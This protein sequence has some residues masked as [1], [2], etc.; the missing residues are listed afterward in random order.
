M[1]EEGWRR[2][3]EEQMKGVEEEGGTEERMEAEVDKR[4]AGRIL[5]Q[6]V[7]VWVEMAG[8]EGKRRA[9]KVERGQKMEGWRQERGWME[10]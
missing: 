8:P 9:G 10:C 4:G 3:G 5:L 7:V 1:G 6:E 2:E